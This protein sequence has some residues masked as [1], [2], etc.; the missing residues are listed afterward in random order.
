MDSP[1]LLLIISIAIIALVF[2]DNELRP[3]DA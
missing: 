3:P 1:V 2:L